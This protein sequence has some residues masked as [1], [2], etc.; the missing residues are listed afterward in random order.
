VRQQRETQRRGIGEHVTGIGQ[1]CQRSANQPPTL[2][3]TE[4]AGE[5]ERPDQGAP[6][7][8]I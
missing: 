5:N 2:D 8:W 4:P 3:D 6:R 1:Q 7:G